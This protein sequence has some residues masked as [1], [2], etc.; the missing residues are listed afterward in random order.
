MTEFE[1]SLFIDIHWWE[2]LD[3]LWA[4]FVQVRNAAGQILAEAHSVCVCETSEQM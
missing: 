4:E 3:T 1:G 2:A